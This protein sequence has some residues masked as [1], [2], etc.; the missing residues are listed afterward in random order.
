VPQFIKDMAD[1][2]VTIVLEVIGV[3]LKVAFI[4][5]LVDIA[6]DLDHQVALETAILVGAVDFLNGQ[7]AHFRTVTDVK[8]RISISDRG[9]RI[10]QTI[11]K[12]TSKD[13]R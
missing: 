11:T 5:L 8:E 13:T 9:K 4:Y 7:R 1:D 6:T 10:T 3:T 2:L 12:H